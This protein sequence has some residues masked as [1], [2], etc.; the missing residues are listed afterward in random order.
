MELTMTSFCQQGFKTRLW[1]F[2]KQSR[3]VFFWCRNLHYSQNSNCLLALLFLQ[4]L[5][6]DSCDGGYHTA[7]LRPPLMLIPDG[8]WFCPTCE[9]VS[10]TC[11][12]V[13]LS[14]KKFRLKYTMWWFKNSTKWV[15][16]EHELLKH[17]FHHCNT[18]FATGWRW[19]CDVTV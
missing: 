6:C 7:C 9:H 4:I 16:L 19:R 13:I 2:K 17:G 8:D 1:R 14:I 12:C 3:T 11:G 18:S 5:L 15:N 10:G